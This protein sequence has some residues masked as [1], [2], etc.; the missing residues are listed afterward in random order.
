[1][2]SAVWSP[3]NPSTAVCSDVSGPGCGHCDDGTVSLGAEPGAKPG[4]MAEMQVAV[5]RVSCGVY[6]GAEPWHVPCC[7]V[8]LSRERP[9]SGRAPQGSCQA[10]CQVPCAGTSVTETE[11][12]M[13]S[14]RLGL[15][16][17]ALPGSSQG[18]GTVWLGSHRRGLSVL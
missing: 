11:L 15:G 9:M 4:H 6:C 3:C 17:S 2:G 10:G 18:Q 14:I 16:C 7:H 12:P 13:P 8:L 5:H 1:M